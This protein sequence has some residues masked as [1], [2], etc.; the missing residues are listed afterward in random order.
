MHER[1]AR[2]GRLGRGGGGGAG[3]AVQIKGSYSADNFARIQ[4]FRFLQVTW[5][6]LSL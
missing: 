6:S 1:G 5:V 4:E 2:E 3:A